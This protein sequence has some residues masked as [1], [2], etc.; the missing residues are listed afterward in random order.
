MINKI[1]NGSV[2]VPNVK[3]KLV[4]SECTHDD[5]D[6]KAA[7]TLLEFSRTAILRTQCTCSCSQPDETKTKMAK[8]NENTANEDKDGLVRFLS[9]YLFYKCVI[10]WHNQRYKP[11]GDGLVADDSKFQGERVN[12]SYI[13]CYLFVTL[14]A[15]IR[16][17]NKRIIAAMLR[18]S[19]FAELK[20]CWDKSEPISEIAT[21]W[22]L[23]VVD[24]LSFKVDWKCVQQ[25]PLRHCLENISTK[26]ID[27]IEISSIVACTLTNIFHNV[28]KNEVVGEGK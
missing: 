16:E 26:Y 2:V 14:T 18:R 27:C 3:S 24:K 28:D 12:M 4:T 15:V 21:N 5:N 19:C 8:W 13:W 1:I 11:K 20:A 7:A 17:H 22:A 10:I 6:E 25:F 9:E 23:R